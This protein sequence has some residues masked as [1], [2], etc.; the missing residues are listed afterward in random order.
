MVSLSRKL[1]SLMDSVRDRSEVISLY[2]DVETDFI[3][4]ENQKNTTHALCGSLEQ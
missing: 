4:L 3:T 2:L 1:K